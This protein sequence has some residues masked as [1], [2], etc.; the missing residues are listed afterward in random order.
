A[1]PAGVIGLRSVVGGWKGCVMEPAYP[2]DISETTTQWPAAYLWDSN[3]DNVLK[4]P[5]GSSNVHVT[6]ISDGQLDDCNFSA[7]QNNSCPTPLTPLTSDQATLTNALNAMQ[8]WCLSGTMIQVGLAWGWRTISPKSVF[9][10]ANFSVQPLAYNTT[11]WHKAL[12]LMTDGANQVFQG[13]DETFTYTSTQGGQAPFYG[14]P[15]KGQDPGCNRSASGHPA[16]PA[17]GMTP[18]GRLGVSGSYIG[19][20]VTDPATG[21]VVTAG[22]TSI[23]QGL[24]LMNEETAEACAAIKNAG[25]TVYTIAFTGAA[26]AGSSASSS[27]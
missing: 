16:T 13:C 24:D 7:A 27:V 10:S 19:A 18:Y 23:S 20:G 8:A 26:A 17:S 21:K 3:N 15:R 14:S 1:F 2:A 11:G 25:V 12:V 4:K 6:H 5:D 22:A 9:S